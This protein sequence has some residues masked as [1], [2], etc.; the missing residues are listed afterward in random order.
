MFA[1]L[2]EYERS[3]L[4]ERMR[5]G[6][7]AAKARGRLGGRPPAMTAAKLAA[8]KDLRRHGKKLQEIA[9]TL[10]VSMSTLT[11]SLGPRTGKPAA[12]SQALVQNVA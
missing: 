1:S 10:S 6:L 2:A 9:D 11:R 5:A 12:E 7:A 8:A 3:R 4:S